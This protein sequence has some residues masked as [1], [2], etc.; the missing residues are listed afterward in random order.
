MGVSPPANVRRK[1]LQE[2]YDRR[3]KRL[4]P[5]EN[6][7][8][9]AKVLGISEQSAITHLQ[10]V[11]DSNMV[12]GDVLY[13]PESTF[14]QTV[15]VWRLTSKGIEAVEGEFRKKNEREN[16]SIGNVIG[17]QITI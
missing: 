14:P 3:I 6:P 9:W 5:P 7:Q 13:M 11:V 16:V 10:D 12:E 15:L 1:I 17:S 4:E 8:A 2:L